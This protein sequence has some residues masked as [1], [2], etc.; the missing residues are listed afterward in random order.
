MQVALGRMARAFLGTGRYVGAYTRD[1]HIL[2]Y[3]P[4]AFSP[5]LL[6]T[7]S[8]STLSPLN[9]VISAVWSFVMSRDILRICWF[10][11]V[12]SLPPLVVYDGFLLICGA[13]QHSRFKIEEKGMCVDPD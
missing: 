8:M 12:N 4:L 9:V 2:A 1:N 5:H 6:I 7:G 10:W 3:R 13:C 11:Q